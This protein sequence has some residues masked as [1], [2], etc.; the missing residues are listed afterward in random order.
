MFGSSRPGFWNLALW[1]DHSEQWL[2]WIRW[3]I[4][5]MPCKHLG[6]LDQHYTLTQFPLKG[7]LGVKG[8]LGAPRGARAPKW[9]QFWGLFGARAARPGSHSPWGPL[10][11]E[12][13]FFFPL[14]KIWF[15]IRSA[16]GSPLNNMGSL[17]IEH[18]NDTQPWPQPRSSCWSCWWW[19]GPMASTTWARRLGAEHDLV[20]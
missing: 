2:T 13:F 12:I 19:F 18:T 20:I 16:S 5:C 3:S 7:V 6:I 14:A 11:R 15:K 4:G 8:I 17:N 9:L 10:S 1:E